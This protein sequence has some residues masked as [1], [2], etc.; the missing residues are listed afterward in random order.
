MATVIDDLTP[1]VNGVTNTFTT[2]KPFNPDTLCLGY[3]G[4]VYPPKLNIDSWDESAKT[5]TITF[6][7]ETDPNPDIKSKVLI[8]YEEPV[9]AD[10]VGS[11]TPPGV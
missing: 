2:T 8:I 7:P 6:V 3:N 5:V 10:I 1:Q 4:Q 11:A 9:L